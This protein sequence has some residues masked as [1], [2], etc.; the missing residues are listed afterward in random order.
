MDE[1][2]VG[3]DSWLYSVCVRLCVCVCVQALGTQAEPEAARSRRSPL[4]R[5]HR[6]HTTSRRRNSYR[7]SR[8]R[9]KADNVEP[10]GSVACCR[11]LSD[12]G[13]SPRA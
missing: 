9:N 6:P 7:L 5:S 3:T 2:G 12:L 11:L 8:N 4:C 1:V 10:R 13:W